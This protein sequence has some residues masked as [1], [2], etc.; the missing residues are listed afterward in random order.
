MKNREVDFHTLQFICSLTSVLKPKEALSLSEWANRY[1]ILPKGSNEA[2]HYSTDNAPYQKEIMDA[3]TS[4]EVVDVTI[5]SSA[6]VGKTLMILCGIAYYID[7]EPSTQL[8][9]LPTLKL[10]ENFSKTRLATMISDVSVLSDKVMPVKSKDSNNTIY[11]KA[12]PGGHIIVAGANSA[13]SLSSNPCRVVWMDEVDRYPESAGSEGNPIKLAEKRSTSY[14]NKK[15]IKTSTPTIDGR[16]KIQDAFNKGTMEEWCVC[17]PSCGVYQKYDFHRLNFEDLTMT[18]EE[19]GEMIPE[20]DWK[21]SDHKWVAEYPERVTKRSFHLNE[22]ASP[23]VEWKDIVESFQDAM[24]QFKRF[25]DPEDLQVFINTVLGEPWKETDLD[26]TSVDDDILQ[27]RAEHYKAEI[28]D[29]VLILTAAIDTQDNRFEVEVKGWG[30]NN[31][32]WGIHKVEIYGDLYRSEVWDELEEYLNTT[33]SFA[34]GTELNIAGFGIDSGGHYTHSVYKWV[35]KMKKKGKKAY[36]LKGYAGKPDLDLLHKKTSVDIKEEQNDGRTYVVDRVML[37]I[38]GVDTG[39]EHVTNWLKID[40]PGEG[41][42]HFPSN[43]GKGYDKDYYK[44][45]LSEKKIKKKVRGIVKDVWVKEKGV[46]NEPLDLFVYNYAVC[47]LLRPVW[48][49]LEKKLSN[50]INYMKA[51]KKIKTARRRY[52]G[53]EV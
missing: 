12:Y 15:H 21:E 37:N 22:M 24:D 45:L 40:T 17:C 43:G 9:V 11:F 39:K 8:M 35:K 52:G 4:P 10:G 31:E 5:M 1:M 7:H 41:Y 32:N 42:C 47:E 46:R 34:N 25:H 36:A 6:Q 28:P 27:E 26:D 14:W 48:G 30:R 3:I 44:G 29:G 19:C 2:G 33:F 23:Y 49:D 18:C 53:V 38:L 13:P 16:S 51:K 50:G 20:R